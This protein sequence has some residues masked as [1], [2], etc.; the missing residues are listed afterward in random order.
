L[1]FPLL[2]CELN[3]YFAP[4]IKLTA[5]EQ[6]ALTYPVDCIAMRIWNNPVQNQM[7]VDALIFSNKSLIEMLDEFINSKAETVVIAPIANSLALLIS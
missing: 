3:I 1:H 4:S 2:P 6:G 7:L 5:E